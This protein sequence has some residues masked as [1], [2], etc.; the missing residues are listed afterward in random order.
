MLKRLLKPEVMNLFV[1]AIMLVVP[2]YPKFP[3][4]NVPGTFVSIRVEDIIIALASFVILGRILTDKFKIVRNNVLYAMIIFLIV[5][6]VSLISALF[7]TK[8][9]TLHIGLLHWFRRLEYFIPFLLGFYALRNIKDLNFYFKT[10]IIA[11]LVI[12]VYGAGQRYLNWPI[13]A[14][15]NEEYSKG[16]A[17]RFREGGHISST[18]AGHYDLSTFLVLVLPIFINF[19]VLSFK[20]LK[21][22]EN[23]LLTFCILG[24]MWLIAVSGS[25]ISSVTFLIS[26]VIALFLIKKYK[27]I[28]FLIII[29]IFISS[30]SPSLKARYMRLYE[31]TR[32][33]IQNIISY[34]FVDV[35]IANESS[36]GLPQKRVVIEPSPTPLPPFEDRSTSIRL[37]VE[38][39]R[40]VRSFLK[41]PLLGTG[42]SSISLATDNDYLRLLGEIGLLGFLSFT[43]LLIHIVLEITKHFP[44]KEYEPLEL[45]FITGLSGGI[46]GI[47]VNGTFIDIFEA[48]KFATIFWLLMGILLKLSHKYKY[49]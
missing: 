40:A 44:F 30:I 38:W 7:I 48:S 43:L 49:E 32:V 23:V 3:F 18:F 36:S 27:F 35:A 9:I 16:V 10:M 42:Y 46:I 22:T 45:A 4:I 29:S 20:K 8:T 5:G 14:T 12:I 47:L 6:F 34:D 28:P 26:S 19:L 25:R 41:N 33:E 37:N 13:I 39:P 31:V 24:G 11:L 21:A 17:L 15:Q 1:V 2:L